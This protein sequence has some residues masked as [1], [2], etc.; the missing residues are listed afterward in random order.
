MAV[1]ELGS[2]GSLL[3]LVPLIKAL[4]SLQI[5]IFTESVEVNISCS[6]GSGGSD[7]LVHSA[8]VELVACL[9]H[10]HD[11]NAPQT[12]RCAMSTESVRGLLN[13]VLDNFGQI[14]VA[15]F[16]VLASLKAAKGPFF[17]GCRVILCAEQPVDL[18]HHFRRHVIDVSQLRDGFSD[19]ILH[20]LVIS[21]TESGMPV[22]KNSKLGGDY[23]TGATLKALTAGLRN[24]LSE[25][26]PPLGVCARCVEDGGNVVLQNHGSEKA[27]VDVAGELED[28]VVLPVSTL[29]Q[30]LS[31]L[32]LR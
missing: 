5:Q 13:A 12:S 16:T 17:G 10:T 26:E 14:E 2:S 3:V 22:I 4:V 9:Q 6:L 30:M 18:G 25:V 1:Q 31:G 15:K 28:V 23:V 8:N 32:F 7:L 20:P 29:C 27:D 24:L 21:G 11:I 19:D